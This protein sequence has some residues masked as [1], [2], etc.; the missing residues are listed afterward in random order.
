MITDPTAINLFYVNLEG[1]PPGSTTTP[2]F[3]NSTSKSNESS[4][5]NTA[6]VPSV[7]LLTTVRGP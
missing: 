4:S 7:V 3:L 1:V 6:S 2:Q 5:T